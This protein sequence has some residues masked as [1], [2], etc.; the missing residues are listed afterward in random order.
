MSERSTPGRVHVVV[1]APWKDAVI[2]HLEPR[3]PYRPWPALPDARRG[4][5]VVV[6]VD[7]E[8]RVVLTDVARVGASGGVEEAITGMTNDWTFNQAVPMSRIGAGLADLRERYAHFEGAA[9][10]ELIN[11]LDESR[12]RDEAADRFGHSTMAAALVLLESSG[13]C[14]GCGAALNLRGENARDAVGIW[15]VES[16]PRSPF[17]WPATLCRQCQTAMRD[18]GFQTFLDYRFSRHPACP[19]CG[20]RRTQRAMFGMLSSSSV[21]TPWR[22]ARGCCVTDQSWTCALC[23]RQW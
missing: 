3:S 1:G 6:V 10:A 14:T 17:D 13:T 20:G 7:S 2:T 8:P 16:A 12:F 19:S 11:S 21:I 9:A 4:D 15:T 23:F 5:G 22:D 18:G